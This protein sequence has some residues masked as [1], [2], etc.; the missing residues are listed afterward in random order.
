MRVAIIG[1][2][3]TGACAA[4]ELA[5]CGCSVDILEAGSTLV[6]KASFWNEGKIHLGFVYAKDASAKT[7]RLMIRGKDS[8][9]NGTSAP[10]FRLMSDS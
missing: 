6:S 3:L 10:V 2:G 1:G 5:E 8:P 4:L 9:V 7:A